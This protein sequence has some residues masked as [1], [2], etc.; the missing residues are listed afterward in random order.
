MFS[1]SQYE[2]S[3]GTNNSSMIEMSQHMHRVPDFH[4]RTTPTLCELRRARRST[5]V[6]D[7]ARQS[8]N[9]SFSL[10]RPLFIIIFPPQTKKKIGE[11]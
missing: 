9:L 10:S 1:Q 2:K 11:N 6:I 8:S 7:R 3:N 4:K 5:P